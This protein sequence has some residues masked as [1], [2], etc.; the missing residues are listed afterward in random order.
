MNCA[1]CD[2]HLESEDGDVIKE[3]HDNIFCE[4]CYLE[5]LCCVCGY[6]I[7]HNIDPNYF[8]CEKCT[9]SVSLWCDCVMEST[10]QDQH[11][12]VIC[13]ECYSCE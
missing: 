9:R 5:K 6:V 8:Y 1:S 4:T 7:P 10:I 11:H 2:C 12:G 3:C 13:K